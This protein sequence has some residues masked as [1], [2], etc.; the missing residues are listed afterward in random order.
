MQTAEQ[1][2]DLKA[3]FHLP[4]DGTAA[5]NTILLRWHLMVHVT[6]WRSLYIMENWT[7]ACRLE[8]CQNYKIPGVP[9]SNINTT[10]WMCNELTYALRFLQSFHCREHNCKLTGISSFFS[11]YSE[12]LNGHWGVA[13]KKNVYSGNRIAT[14]IWRV[15]RFEFYQASENTHFSRNN[16]LCRSNRRK[17]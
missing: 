3:C 13:R 1:N 16:E 2:F 17:R 10:D 7:F 12:C 11:G 9:M 5:L 8:P 15:M 4:S 14:S 6:I